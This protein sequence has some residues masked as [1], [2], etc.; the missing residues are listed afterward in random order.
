MQKNAVFTTYQS[1]YVLIT[2]YN[3]LKLKKLKNALNFFVKNYL[4]NNLT[5]LKSS[6]SLA[7]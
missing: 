4:A 7:T 6:L 2:V 3:L 1:N 5:I